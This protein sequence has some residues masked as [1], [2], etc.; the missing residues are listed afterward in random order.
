M[1]SIQVPSID[2]SPFLSDEGI[3]A[4][5]PQQATPCQLKVAQEIN[6]TC[7]NHAFLHLVNLGIS[8]HLLNSA[9]RLS[10]EMFQLPR[11]VKEEKMKRIDV[12]TNTGYSPYASESLNRARAGRDKK[13]A[14][15]IRYS[16]NDYSACPTGFEEMADE[17]LTGVQQLARRY[18]IACALALG[19]HEE[20]IDSTLYFHKTLTRMDLCTIRMLHYPPVHRYENDGTDIGASLQPIRAG[21]HTDFGAYTFLLLENE[22]SYKGLQI[23]PA[24]GGEIGGLH[25]GELSDDWLDVVPS[26]DSEG[27]GA[28]VNT[29][30]LM[31]RWTNDIWRATAHRVVVPS[32]DEIAQRD[33]YTIACFIDPDSDAV[34]DV[35][36]QFFSETVPKK[37]DPTTGIDFLRAKLKELQGL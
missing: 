10:K 8:E 34:V 4:D 18:S 37:Y 6:T 26:S 7:R 14:F 17:L 36:P 35:H 31:A 20:S 16:N 27:V 22:L 11:D 12:E 21:E 33:R 1:P 9:F 13:E 3:V 23:K 25:G 15:N 29:G 19:I 2:F 30:A 28:I 24:I 5:P 32:D